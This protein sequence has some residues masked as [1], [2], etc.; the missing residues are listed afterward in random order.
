MKAQFIRCG[1]PRLSEYSGAVLI[2]IGVALLIEFYRIPPQLPGPGLSGAIALNLCG[3]V[4][5]IGWRLS[6]TLDIPS[7]GQVFLWALAVVLVTISGSERWL[8]KR[9]A[10]T[11]NGRESQ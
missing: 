7:R 4:F 11:P 1:S 3:A 2:G 8:M 9:K 5:L 10:T 6:G